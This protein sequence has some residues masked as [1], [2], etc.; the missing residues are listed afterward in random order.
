MERHQPRDCQERPNYAQWHHRDKNTFQLH[1]HWQRTNKTNRSKFQGASLKKRCSE[2]YL[3]WHKCRAWV[4][5]LW[6]SILRKKTYPIHPPPPHLQ[7]HIRTHTRTL[8][9]IMY[10][11]CYIFDGW[12]LSNVL[13]LIIHVSPHAMGG[14]CGVQILW[15]LRFLY[16]WENTCFSLSYW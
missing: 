2:A 3:K 1:R 16:F 9:Y 4:Q 13:S 12:L 14:Y 7:Y 8:L 11:S 15:L 10:P 6:E 5:R